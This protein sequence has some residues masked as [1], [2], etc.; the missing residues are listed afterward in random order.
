MF[1]IIIPDNLRDENE[2]HIISGNEQQIAGNEQQIAQNQYAGERWFLN[3]AIMDGLLSEEYTVPI[4]GIPDESA[5]DDRW[6]LNRA[7]KICL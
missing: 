1:K 2:P 6:F 7:G 3:P 4:F 5:D